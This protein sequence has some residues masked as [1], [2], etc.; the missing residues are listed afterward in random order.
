VQW[1]AASA[2]L[3]RADAKHA[4]ELLERYESLSPALQREVIARTLSR[5]ALARAL[6][7]L[8]AAEKFSPSLLATSEL[9]Q[10]R[11]H[12]DGAIRAHATK[13][14]PK[15]ENADRAA[16]IAQYAAALTLSANHK[17]GAELFQKQCATCHKLGGIGHELG[18]NLAAMKNRGREAILVNVLDP[19]REVNPQYKTYNVITTDG[20]SLS[21]MLTAETA[22]SITLTQAE[23]KA[24]TVLRIDIESLRGSGLSLMPEGLEKVLDPQQLADVMAFIM[25]QE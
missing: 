19:N 11:Q 6:L 22:S 3:S 9:E 4:R 18:P 8:I 1:A 17:R 16:L 5:S 25:A 14:L 15:L 24:E 2:L 20:R 13:V 21:G 12:P 23:G 7:D 10:L